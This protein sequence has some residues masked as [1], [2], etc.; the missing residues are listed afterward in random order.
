M[1]R[2]KEKTI[3]M[4]NAKKELHNDEYRI[5][6]LKDKRK[7]RKK[8][9]IIRMCLRCLPAFFITVIVC[10]AILAYLSPDILSKTSTDIMGYISV[11]VTF[12]LAVSIYLYDTEMD[13]RK[14]NDWKDAYTDYLQSLLKEFEIPQ[15]INSENFETE[16]ASVSEE[17]IQESIVES[18]K[19]SDNRDIIAMMLKNYGEI[20]EYFK[21][22]KSQAK[23][24]YRLSV[25]SCIVGIVILGISIYGAIVIKSLELA[26]VGIVAGAI[27]EVIS[28][29]VLWVHNK[30]ALQ[31]NHY[32]DALHENEKFL[33]AV[34]IAE[35]LSDNA[36]EE[37]YVE[38]IKKQIE[39]K[40]NN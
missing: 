33:S 8:R 36:R 35:K 17:T 6:W 29:T 23:S 13:E 25:A 34:S 11:S 28:G 21:I 14:T 16:S 20:T 18:A 32:Y 2:K 30:S 10:I 1:K 19:K 3:P 39:P 26:I 4:K 12:A 9:K 15:D 31:L 27:V 24:S 7:R 40:N 5:L 22:S 37:I 38:I